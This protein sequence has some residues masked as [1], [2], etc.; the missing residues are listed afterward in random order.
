MEY[1]PFLVPTK[2][3]LCT[4]SY[5]TT[6]TVTIC[7]SSTSTSPRVPRTTTAGQTRRPSS[8]DS[9]TGRAPFG[10]RSAATHRAPLPRRPQTFRAPRHRRSANSSTISSHERERGTQPQP[11]PTDERAHVPAR[12]EIHNAHARNPHHSKNRSTSLLPFFPWL[13][14]A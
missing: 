4:Q 6:P 2:S 14:S 3:K 11:P 5:N 7:E 9:S 8:A 1:F 13:L 10:T 12:R